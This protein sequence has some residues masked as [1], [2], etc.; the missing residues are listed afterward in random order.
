[1]SNH[2]EVDTGEAMVMDEDETGAIAQ[3]VLPDDGQGPSHQEMKT[4]AQ[5][6]ETSKIYARTVEVTFE[7]LENKLDNLAVSKSAEYIKEY[8]GNIPKN[9]LGDKIKDFDMA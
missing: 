3:N 1:M 6:A 8:Q 7:E 5:R 4:P 9:H 2:G